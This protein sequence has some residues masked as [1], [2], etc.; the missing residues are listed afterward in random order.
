MEPRAGESLAVRIQ[1]HQRNFDGLDTASLNTMK[2]QL[3]QA[4]SNRI[5]GNGVA[6]Q[7]TEEIMIGGLAL[8][9][10]T[11]E[12]LQD[13]LSDVCNALQKRNPGSTFTQIT[14][15]D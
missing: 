5:A 14:F 10:V 4:I 9:A 1:K 6:Q 3:Q 8:R 11:L 2:A 7:A 15:C 13:Q 12:E